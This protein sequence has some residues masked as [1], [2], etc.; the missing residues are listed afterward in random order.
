[1]IRKSRTKYIT[2]GSMSSWKREKN[3]TVEGQRARGTDL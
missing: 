2:W 1:M 3:E